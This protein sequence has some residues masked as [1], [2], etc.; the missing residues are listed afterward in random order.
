MKT[1]DCD[2]FCC[3]SVCSVNWALSLLT[4]GASNSRF[5]LYLSCTLVQWFSRRPQF[6]RFHW[7]FDWIFFSSYLSQKH[8]LTKTVGSF[9]L[10]ISL[11]TIAG[12]HFAPDTGT[13]A[14]QDSHASHPLAFE[15]ALA[16]RLRS[17]ERQTPMASGRAESWCLQIVVNSV[18]QAI[19]CLRLYLHCIPGLLLLN[20][21]RHN[22]GRWEIEAPVNSRV[23]T[24][25][26]MLTGC[27]VWQKLRPEGHFWE[28]QQ[29]LV[30]WVFQKVR[31]LCLHPEA[32]KYLE[33][34]RPTRFFL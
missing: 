28:T 17:R 18:L 16:D 9:Q 32:E 10:N 30:S 26:L 33:F 19:C 12:L 31:R 3:S 20:M 15:R 11:W 4:L 24:I 14:P 5:R 13:Q 7:C 1:R 8:L 21:V 27:L 2:T 25:Y 34:S 22:T 23:S 6:L 29:C